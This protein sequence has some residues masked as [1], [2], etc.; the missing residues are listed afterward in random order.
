[1]LPLPAHPRP[2]SA[3][4]FRTTRVWRARLRGVKQ[5]GHSMY[6]VILDPCAGRRRQC[7]GVS[8]A[9]GS[10]RLREAVTCRF[11]EVVSKGQR[12]D[13]GPASHSHC[14]STAGCTAPAPA[15]DVKTATWPTSKASLLQA[16]LSS[17]NFNLKDGKSTDLPPDVFLP[18]VS[19]FT[20]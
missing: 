20:T 14:P 9:E 3:L 5:A 17:F 11:T 2:I 4:V 13:T 15:S 18:W 10:P 8:S 7:S 6:I 16:Q 1:M 12:G 19:C